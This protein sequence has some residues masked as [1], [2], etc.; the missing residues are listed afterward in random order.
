MVDP[1]TS[2]G[3]VLAVVPLIIS[4]LENYEYTFQP[5]IIF[6]SR[7]RREVERFQKTLKVQKVLFAE[8]CLLLLQNV[9]SD[10]GKYMIHNLRH[11]LWQDE[12][13]ENWL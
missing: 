6:S 12:D 9:T 10:Q 11:S 3:L 2:A 8:E 4:A 13:L 1:V 7:Y 5:I